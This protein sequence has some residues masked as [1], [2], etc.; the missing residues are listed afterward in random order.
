[1]QSSKKSY[2]LFTNL[3][4]KSLV[5]VSHL[6]DSAYFPRQNKFTGLDVAVKV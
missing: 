2:Q 4:V 6:E 3:S 5:F 1:M